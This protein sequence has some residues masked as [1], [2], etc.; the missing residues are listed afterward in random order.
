MAINVLKIINTNMK[1]KQHKQ[2][3]QHIT[4]N[5][6]IRLNYIGEPLRNCVK[7]TID[8]ALP[9]HLETL[10]DILKGNLLHIWLE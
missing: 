8:F 10:R 5:I 7:P 9:Q 6:K 4:L 1:M 3:L 2:K